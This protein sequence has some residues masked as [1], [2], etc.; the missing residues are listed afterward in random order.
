MTQ[1]YHVFILNT[2]ILKHICL[3]IRQLDNIK[4]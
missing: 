1:V 3:N 4:Q 2:V